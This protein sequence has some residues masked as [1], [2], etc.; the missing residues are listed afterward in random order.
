MYL[1]KNIHTLNLGG[2]DRSNFTL[3]DNP[4]SVAILQWGIVGVN[5]TLTLLCSS[6]TDTSCSFTTSNCSSVRGCSG[7]FMSLKLG[8]QKNHKF[9]AI[10]YSSIQI[11]CLSRIILLAYYL[12]KSKIS[13]SSNG[14]LQLSSS[15]WG[16]TILL[17]MHS[18]LTLGLILSGSLSFP[19]IPPGEASILAADGIF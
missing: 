19:L 14:S 8:Y 13:L 2:K 18:R 9:L 1:L 11:I 17:P 3:I 4:M 6:S 15:S 10:Y 16:V 7:S 5:T 12:I